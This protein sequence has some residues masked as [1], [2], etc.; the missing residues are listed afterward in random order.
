[1]KAVEESRKD[2]ARDEYVECSVDGLER[3]LK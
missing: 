3:V 2:V 1:L